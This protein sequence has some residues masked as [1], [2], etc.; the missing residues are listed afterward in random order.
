MEVAIENLKIR[1]EHNFIATSKFFYQS[2]SSETRP[3]LPAPVEEHEAIIATINGL[4]DT[5]QKLNVFFGDADK[6]ISFEEMV[7][8]LVSCSG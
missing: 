5:L 6:E 8:T 4:S 2:N 3:N 1:T 7:D